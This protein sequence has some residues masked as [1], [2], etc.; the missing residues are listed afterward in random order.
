MCSQQQQSR[1]SRQSTTRFNQRG[2][3]VFCTPFPS[4][5]IDEC[6]QGASKQEQDELSC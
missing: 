6:V 5:E 2:K 1:P 4:A 3:Q